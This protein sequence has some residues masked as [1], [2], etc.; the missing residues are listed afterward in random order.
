MSSSD[1]WCSRQASSSD[2]S[3]T[4]FVICALAAILFGGAEPILAEGTMR[5]ISVK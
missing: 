1:P 4:V 3:S 2:Q 5:Y